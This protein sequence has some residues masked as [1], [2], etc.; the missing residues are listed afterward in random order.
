M[1]TST[2][3]STLST[4]TERAIPPHER[5]T[6]T[7][8]RSPLALEI[9]YLVLGAICQALA[10]ACFIA[11]A[12]IVPGGCYGLSITI[13]YLTQGT[14]EAFPEGLPIGAVALCFNVPF[15]L[16]AA[17]SLGLRSGGKTIATFLL[18]SICTDLITTMTRD[19]V[20]VSND[21][22]LSSVYGGAILGLGVLLT[23]KAGSTSAGTDVIARVLSKGNNLKT[24]HMIIAVDS[25][26]VLFGLVAFGDVSVPLYSWI[27]IFV[28]GKV[29]DFLQPENPNKAIFIVSEHTAELRTLI[30]EQL[31]LR[32]TFLHGSGI[33]AGA[34]RDIIFMIVERKHV[35]KLKKAVL[36]ADPKAFIATTNATND[37][38]P[39][40]I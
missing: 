8:R 33:Y 23:F 37:T 1:P 31:N 11:P 21:K 32:G 27:T 15:F 12:N 20:I 18:I 28:Y 24:S 10:Y 4:P 9:L 6:F 7:P 34:E 29:V 36:L 38:A 2:S 14:F 40:I 3:G 5:Q 17:R 30:I 25:A 16:L 19:M 26:V 22:F 13:N 39:K 35:N